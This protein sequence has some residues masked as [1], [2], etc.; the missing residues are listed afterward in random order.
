MITRNT[1]SLGT[2]QHL[3]WLLMYCS[4]VTYK[5]KCKTLDNHLLKK[6][7][8]SARHHTFQIQHYYGKV[9]KGNAY[10]IRDNI[11]HRREGLILWILF[12]QWMNAPTIISVR[13]CVIWVSWVYFFFFLSNYKEI[14]Y[15]WQ[16]TQKEDFL[17]IH[18]LFAKIFS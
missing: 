8:S 4:L 17:F 3:W 6:T 15:Q 16:A 12:F 11:Y 1:W 13:M 5:K 18:I 7:F 2:L 14:V 9:K 10:S